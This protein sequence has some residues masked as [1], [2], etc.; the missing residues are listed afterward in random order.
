[1][2]LIAGMFT[3]PEPGFIA[4]NALS[5]P[6][7]TNIAIRDWT[8]FT[9]KY[10]AVLAAVFADT[11]EK[12]GDTVAN[13][14]T[15]YNVVART[16]LPFFEHIT[17]IGIAEEFT[18]HMASQGRSHGLGLEHLVKGFDWGALGD[19]AHVIDVSQLFGA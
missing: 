17:E 6:F 5:L 11:T 9:I 7:A 1:M 13:N 19:N 12:W 8:N 3:E 2:A 15:A 10:G 16:H 18:R 4:H 14:E